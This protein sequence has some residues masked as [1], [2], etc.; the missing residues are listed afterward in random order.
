MGHGPLGNLSAEVGIAG[1]SFGFAVILGEI[2]RCGRTACD[3]QASKSAANDLENRFFTP[4][5]TKDMLNGGLSPK[6][7]KA[8]R[9]Y[10]YMNVCF[11]FGQ[12]VFDTVVMR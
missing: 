4:P 9:R 3:K 1:I 2:K 5:S 12:L 6:P 10:L 8:N 11:N 7:L